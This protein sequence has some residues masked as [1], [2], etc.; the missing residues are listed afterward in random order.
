MIEATPYLT[1]EY[2]DDPEIQYLE[3]PAPTPMRNHMPEWFKQLKA[4]KPDVDI[5]KQQT[6]RNCLGFRGLA[7]IGYTIPLPEDIDGYDTY[8]SRGRLQPGMIDGTLFSNKGTVPFAEDD[9]SLYEYRMKLLCYPWRA[10]MDPGWRLLILPYLLDWSHDWQEFAGIVEPNYDLR[11]F[12][13]DSPTQ[14]G[15]SLN[16]TQVIDK[17]YNY[18]NLETVIASKRSV[19]KVNKGTLTFC[20]VPLFD[21]ELLD[22]QTKGVYNDNMD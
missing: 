4:K 10:K 6:I 21:P 18:Y 3:C 7:N 14:I 16:W 19:P 9:F 22:K 8:F 5:A 11:P 1:W 12:Y 2:C 20:A 15:S 17:R 13:T